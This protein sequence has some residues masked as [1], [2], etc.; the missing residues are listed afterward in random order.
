[1]TKKVKATRFAHF[2]RDTANQDDRTIELSVSSDADG[3][4]QWVPGIGAV[5]EVLGH[6]PTEVI[7]DRFQGPHGGPLLFNHNFGELIGRFTATALVDGKLRGTARFGNSPLAESLWR[8]LCDGIL[9]DVSITY[10]YDARDIEITE[11]DGEG[12]PAAIRV[13]RWTP[14]EVSFVT[15]PADASVGV[16]RSKRDEDED[17]QEKDEDDDRSEDT[18]DEDE[19]DE[20]RSESEDEDDD[21]SEDDEDEDNEERSES[22][23]DEDEKDED[24]EERSKPRNKA[25]Q[26]PL[27][28]PITTARQGRKDKNMKPKGAKPDRVAEILKLA[29]HF[30]VETEKRNAWIESGASVSAVRKEILDGF[31]RESKPLPPMS[32]QI[33]LTKD[34]R[35]KYSVAKAVRYLITQ[36]PAEGAFEREVSAAMAKT[37]GLSQSRS[38]ILVPTDMQMRA[39]QQVKTPEHGGN[40]VFKEY[41]GFLEMLKDAAVVLQMG[42]SFVG[43]LQ[44]NPTWVRQ[45][46]TSK[47]FWMDENPDDDVAESALEFNIV[48]ATPKT[49]KSRL[50][51]TRQM[52][53]QSIEAFEPILQKDL[54]ENDALVIDSAALVGSGSDRQPRGLLET[55][56]I[57]AVALGAN[58]AKPTYA[59]LTKLKTLVKRANALGLGS[60]GYLT[61]P[62]IEDLLQNTAKLGN[63]IAQPVWD[64]DTVAGYKALGANQVPDTLSRGTAE[65]TC[66][67]I[68]FGIW[69]ELFILEWGALEMI[70]DPYTGAGRDIVKI[71]TS[72]LVDVFVRRP[73]AFAAIKDALDK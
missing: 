15:V 19:D 31:Q 26:K 48:T 53:L 70:I 30:N 45:T 7:L 21:R 38:G 25:P 2:K 4:R 24:D 49:A 64:N 54:L 71:T 17:E 20:E 28:P 1:V 5:R 46:E 66:H 73:K 58:G 3:I 12:H 35:N 62:E 39:T 44:G 33:G 42:A 8:D 55:P 13:K 56:D 29:D 11:T 51:Y 61:T 16:D 43:G 23:D 52:A 32:D 14:Y 10:D 36:D 9:V 27:T 37:L 63:T 41:M 40:L 67:A 59:N 65:K 50:K 18:D 68:I 57:G 6:D 72:H 22:E 47:F 69:S 60:G 34:E